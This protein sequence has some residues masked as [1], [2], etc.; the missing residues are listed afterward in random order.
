[1]EK[2]AAAEHAEQE[3][4]LE[5]PRTAE[6]PTEEAVN[7]RLEGLRD[8]RGQLAAALNS[9]E[10][11]FTDRQIPCMRR[12]QYRSEDARSS[13]RILNCE[14]DADTAD[15]G[16]GVGR[17]ADAE[18]AGETPAAQ[19]VH[20]DWKKRDLIPRLDL[21]NAGPTVGAGYTEEGNKCA[22]SCRK[23]SNPAG[24]MWVSK[25]PLRMM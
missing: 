12:A 1:M 24:L 14:I 15:R 4:S 25:L 3:G 10:Q 5:R 2:P 17:I 7:G 18:Q 19:S 9:G 6:I 21:V 16:H 13:H 8:T 23:A 22:R 20:L 11:D